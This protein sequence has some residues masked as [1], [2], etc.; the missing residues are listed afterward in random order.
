MRTWH[1]AFMTCGV[2]R[3][4]IDDPANR[5]FVERSAAAWA[6]A[7][8]N[9]GFLGYLPEPNPDG[10]PNRF[11]D[12]EFAHRC[13][14]TLTRWRDLESVYGFAFRSPDHAAALRDR[15]HW[16][17]HGDWPTS[18]AWWFDADRPP[19]QEESLARYDR[20]VTDGPTP[21]AFELRHPFDATGAPVT[22]DRAAAGQT[23]AS[24]PTVTDDR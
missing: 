23:N 24:P 5:S 13:A 18:V 12:H 20:L 8:A 2:L 6:A 22:I 10:R 1:L 7:A 15:S 16:F 4:P 11:G 14:I 21:A 19:T 9:T 3:V 17:L